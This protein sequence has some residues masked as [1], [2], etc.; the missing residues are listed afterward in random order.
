MKT[1]KTLVAAATVSLLAL[2]SAHAGG[3][4]ADTF[5]KPFSPELAR[6]ADRLNHNLGNPVDRAVHAGVD[7]VVPGLGTTLEAVRVIR[8]SGVLNGPSQGQTQAPMGNFCHTQAG[9]FGPGP[10]NPIGS[11]CHANT[12]WGPMAGSVGR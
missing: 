7:A 4:L 6:A 5:I 10:M 9:R 2:S 3:F 8:G 12:P 11:F 1:I